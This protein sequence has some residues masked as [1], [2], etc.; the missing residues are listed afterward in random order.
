MHV[1]RRRHRGLSAPDRRRSGGRAR[2]PNG[3]CSATLRRVVSATAIF[4]R[5][6]PCG[7]GTRAAEVPAYVPGRQA[8]RRTRQRRATA[9][10]KRRQRSL[11]G[12]FPHRHAARRPCRAAN[13]RYRGHHG[14]PYAVAGLEVTMRK[15]G[16]KVRPEDD[17]PG[18]FRVI[19]SAV[20]QGLARGFVDIFLRHGGGPLL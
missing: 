6:R 4:A 12:Q 8:E 9:V 10:A 18:L 14:H 7:L 15:H 2:A 1:S 20:V 5:R 17:S 11:T 16:D 19:L 13:A 3:L